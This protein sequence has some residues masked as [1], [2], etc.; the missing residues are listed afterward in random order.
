MTKDIIDNNLLIGSNK[1][2]VIELLGKDFTVPFEN[3]MAYNIHRPKIMFS[4]DHNV[5]MIYFD[6]KGIVINVS[7]FSI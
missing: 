6:E 7:E 3:S 4:I 1:S 5:L 2:E